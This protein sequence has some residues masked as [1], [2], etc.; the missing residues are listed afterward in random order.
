[1]SDGIRPPY[2]SIYL[3]S[4]LA[5]LWGAGV[6]TVFRHVFGGKRMQVLERLRALQMAP[7]EDEEDIL[8]QPFLKRTVGPLAKRLAATLGQVAPARVLRRIED[9]LVKAGNPRNLKPGD[10]L[11]LQ[12][13]LGLLTLG[14]SIL[15]FRFMEISAIRVAV[16]SLALGA[17]AMY[18]PLFYLSRLSIKRQQDIRRSLPDVMDFL[19]ISLEAGLTF[20]LALLRVVEKFRGTAGEEFQ[21]ALREIQLGKPRKDALQDMANRVGIEELSF[22]VNAIVQAE[23]LGVGLSNVLRLQA[24]LMREKRQQSIEEQ[25]MK[26]PIKMLFPLIFFIFPSIFVI[27]LGPAILN[28]LKIFSGR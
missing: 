25:A 19:V 1:M 10:L 27:I 28:I 13:T 24:D 6:F 3:I 18:L 17:V 21:R 22:L 4:F 2:L 23:Q 16:I 26:A 9:R 7:P 5:A 20:D 14:A 11:V 12:G 8:K 15:I